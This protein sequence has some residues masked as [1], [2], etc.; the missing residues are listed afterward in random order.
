MFVNHV[1]N[2]AKNLSISVN[3]RMYKDILLLQFSFH[4]ILSELL[5]NLMRIIHSV[6]NPFYITSVYV[7]LAWEKNY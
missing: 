4:I 3:M 5:Q 1:K 2:I 7:G 6:W